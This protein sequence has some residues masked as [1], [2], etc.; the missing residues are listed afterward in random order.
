MRKQVFGILSCLLVLLP[1]SGQTQ[2]GVVKT[3]GRLVNGVLQPGKGLAEATVQVA[4]RQPVL[5]HGND[6]NFSFPVTGQKFRVQKVQK[7]GYQLVDY[8][9]CT[10]YRYSENPLRLVMETPQQQQ[11][12]LLAKERT[13]RRNLERQLQQREDEVDALNVSLEKKNRLMEE[14][15]QQREDNEKIISDLAQYYSR[16]DYDQLDEFQQS[17]SDCLE[18]GELERADSLLRS[19]GDMRSRIIAVK[20]EQM[21]EAK[22]EEA[23]AQR[24]RDL[25][26]SKEGTSRRIEEIAADCYYYYQR[27]MQDHKNDSAAY[28]LEL[29]TLLDS[30]NVRWL[31]DLG[32]FVYEYL[33]DARR[34]CE[35]FKKE[36]RQ[37]VARYGEISGEVINA[38]INEL[39]IKA[40]LTGIQ[41]E[42]NFTQQNLKEK[43]EVEQ[44][45]DDLLQRCEQVY[46]ANSI[47]LAIAYNNYGSILLKNGLISDAQSL[48]WKAIQIC[49]SQIESKDI[50]VLSVLNNIASLWY[51]KGDYENAYYYLDD[52]FE[53]GKAFFDDDQPITATLYNNYA[54]AAHKIGKDEESLTYH[55]KALKIRERIY[56]HKHPLI[57]DSYNNL[58]TTLT[59]LEKYDEA[60]ECFGKA[61]SVLSQV[62]DGDGFSQAIIYNNIGLLQIERKDYLEAV[63]CLERALKM[64]G[65]RT[66]RDVKA[67]ALLYNNLA[68][69]Y[70]EQ[71]DFNRAVTAFEHSL[72]LSKE[73]E[74]KRRRIIEDNIVSLH[75]INKDFSKV[76]TANN[77]I[78][79]GI[80]GLNGD[81]E[82]MMDVFYRF[83]EDV[84]IYGELP[85]SQALPPPPVQGMGEKGKIIPLNINTVNYEELDNYISDSEE[86]Y[87]KLIKKWTVNAKDNRLELAIANINFADYYLTERFDRSSARLYYEKAKEI[88]LDTKKDNV[89]LAKIHLC[90]A[91]CER[92][93]DTDLNFDLIRSAIS[94]MESCLGTDNKVVDRYKQLLSELLNPDAN[95]WDD[96]EKPTA[97]PD[98]V[99]PLYE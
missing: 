82:R 6:G 14:I 98:E 9:V 88:I 17:V 53:K 13:L 21:E 61:L 85:R 94:I 80:Y 73:S 24:Q 75:Y 87:N 37:A 49:G 3:R 29:R 22:E 32:V 1:V 41:L 45:L 47:Q 36:K 97:L 68:F 40:L 55:R 42:E 62:D 60:S 5:T 48:Y 20:T 71:S 12:D 7:Q 95:E 89:L 58:G 10:E 2:Q 76:S 64:I 59:K 96:S 84:S 99:E 43:K 25:K 66:V 19:R 31:N 74:E 77:I 90:L 34:A 67:A 11:A 44:E 15:K 39:S 28:Y 4:G 8:G 69:A 54:N 30:T 91:I 16:L 38:S 35:I 93:P 72:V 46:G 56:N 51:E 18:N 70:Y 63:K 79:E 52:F 33:G 23:L 78:M 83:F 50:T 81:Y 26:A 57:A 92:E 65:T 27:F 86:Y